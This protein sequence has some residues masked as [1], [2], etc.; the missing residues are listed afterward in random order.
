[1]KISPL[2]DPG[3]L[4][5]LGVWLLDFSS[6]HVIR[7]LRWSP[8]LYSLL[9]G[10]PASLFPTPLGCALINISNLKKKEK[11]RRKRKR[12]P[13]HSKLQHFLIWTNFYHHVC[14]NTY[15]I[16]SGFFLCRLGSTYKMPSFPPGSGCSNEQ[17]TKTPTSWNWHDSGQRGQETRYLKLKQERGIA[18][19]GERGTILNKVISKHLTWVM[20]EWRLEE[21]EGAKLTSD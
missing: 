20:L 4:S 1:M 2:R 7:V 11:R 21:G 5:R 19:I 3:W 8:A 13:P 10:E 15:L 16:H 6:G 9:R 18:G 12:K 14:S 17:K